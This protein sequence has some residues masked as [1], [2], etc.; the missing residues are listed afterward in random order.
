MQAKTLTMD[1]NEVRL[2]FSIYNISKK[3][4]IALLLEEN[5]TFWFSCPWKPPS[6]PRN[7]T[8]ETETE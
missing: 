3:H 7:W 5:V 8:Q 1:K 6:W 2:F 4:F